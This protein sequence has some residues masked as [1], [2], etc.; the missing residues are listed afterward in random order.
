MRWDGD[1]GKH[2]G[3]KGLDGAP[4][5]RG[6]GKPGGGSPAGRGPGP[7]PGLQETTT[8]KQWGKTAVQSGCALAAVSIDKTARHP[9]PPGPEK[10]PDVSPFAPWEKRGWPVWWW[11]PDAP[12]ARPNRRRDTVPNRALVSSPA[13]AWQPAHSVLP[14]ACTRSRGLCFESRSWKKPF[15]PLLRYRCESLT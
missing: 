10:G 7:G 2:Q 1:G 12:T 3:P 5:K 14:P 4:P 11:T 13:A 9:P 8:E 15:R 6:T